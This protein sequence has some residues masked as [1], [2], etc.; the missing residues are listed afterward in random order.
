[1]YQNKFPIL[2]IFNILLIMEIYFNINVIKL[3]YLSIFLIIFFIERNE[4]SHQSSKQNLRWIN[5]LHI[6]FS[7]VHSYLKLF[8]VNSKLVI[9]LDWLFTQKFRKTFDFLKLIFN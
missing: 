9:K 6:P 4:T 5:S 1:M 3:V 2:Y 8:T 7:E